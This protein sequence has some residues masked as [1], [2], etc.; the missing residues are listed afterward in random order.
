FAN[1]GSFDANGGTVIFGGTTSISGTVPNFHSVQIEDVLNAPS[2]LVVAGNFTNNGTFTHNNGLL[3]MTGT[4]TRTL[5][6]TSALPLYTLNVSGGTVNVNNAAVSITD[7]ITVGASTTLDLDGGGSGITTLLSTASKDAYIAEI[8][9][10]STVSGNLTVQRSIYAQT[11]DRGYHI[12]GFPV[13]GVTVSD[14]QGEIAV[15]GTFTGSSTGTGFDSNPSIYAFN[16]S[17]GATLTFNERYAAFPAADNGESFTNGQ[18]YYVYTYPADMPS[19][20]VGTG[21][22]KTGPFSTNLSRTGVTDGAGWH[23]IANPYP[24][25]SD[26]SL[27]SNGNVEGSTAYLYNPSTMGYDALD[28]IATGIIPQGQGVFVRA[29]SDGVSTSATESTKVT[30]TTSFL[31]NEGLL[32]RFEI[33]LRT[34]DYDDKSIVLLNDNATDGFEPKYDARRLLNT[35]ETIS[36]VSTD[37][38]S[39]KVNRLGTSASNCNKSFYINLEQ[40]KNATD[41]QIV[42]ED[43]DHLP[44]YTFSVIDHYLGT[45]TSISSGDLVSFN[46]NSDAASQGTNR[47]EVVMVANVPKMV[48]VADI[49]VC[50]E[51]NA[52]V[53]IPSTATT[54]TYFIFK[55]NTIVAEI[56]GTGGNVEAAI[57]SS[58]LSSSFNNFIVKASNGICD[59][60]QVASFNV[61]MQA[62]IN[63]DAAVSGSNVCAI[64]T[65]AP[66]SVQ[67]Q[68]GVNYYVLFGTDTLDIFTGDGS[69][70]SRSIEAINLSAGNNEL[71]VLADRPDCSNTVLTNVIEINYDNFQIDTTV[72]VKGSSICANVATASYS[73]KTQSGVEYY[74]IL[75]QDTLDTF[76][77]NGSTLAR[78]VDATKLSGGTN[79][80]DVLVART[81]CGNA[82]LENPII[83]EKDDFEIDQSISYFGNAVC[84]G[85]DGQITIAT[86]DLVQYEL[87]KEGVVLKSFVGNGA[88]QQI[89]LPAELLLTGENNYNLKATYADCQEFTFPA[90]ASV[91]VNDQLQISAIANQQLCI[92]ESAQIQVQSNFEL[93]NYNLF[94]G[95]VLVSQFS[96]NNLS[97]IPTASGDYK[98]VGTTNSGCTSNEVFFNVQLLSLEQPTVFASANILR[99]SIEAESYQW[100]KDGIL[101]EGE[102]NQLLVVQESGSYAVELLNGLCSITSDV[103]SFD[104]SILNASE[105]LASLIAF[106]PNPVRDKLRIEYSDN[107][108]NQLKVTIFT[109]SGVLLSSYE[110]VKNGEMIDLSRLD[111]GLYIIQFSANDMEFSARVIK[112]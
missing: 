15:T 57:A 49:D 66:Y 83:I 78:T 93:A 43:L 85:E 103:Y 44:Q 6:G 30:T 5:G 45:T 7:G 54:N 28:G 64:E 38:E 46:V 55:D 82:T 25:G 98:L 21:A 9:G 77:G 79:A 81:G 19:T 110:E 97:F 48:I 84:I 68:T 35:Y 70:I 53:S 37:G 4:G 73:V 31:R 42:F 13:T 62:A 63:A 36:T 105:K 104:A 34:P 24:A 89:S 80:I 100:Y 26:W 109:T 33:I 99:S 88:E 58:Y 60:V 16:E 94:L 40:M 67:S 91:I 51:A 17:A 18:G 87:I 3:D 47:F 20:I 102:T 59:T 106:Y 96:S 29:I 108:L 52:I 8:P 112:D 11:N 76:T 14:I 90:A 1:N 23:M 72:G 12:M 27:W 86:Q 95:A 92:G 22:V 50:S 74:L 107:G 10:T 41:Y 71:T 32:P 69:V 56:L 75:G 65:S 39:L 101:L 2:T 61:T 111:A